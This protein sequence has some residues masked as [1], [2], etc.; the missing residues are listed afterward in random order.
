[1]DKIC[2]L[3]F[4]NTAHDST[5]WC[6]M[7]ECRC[8]GRSNCAIISDGSGIE[9]EE[10]FALKCA[11]CGWMGHPNLEESGP[12]TKATCG[13]DNCGA[14]IKMLSKADVQLLV[15]DTVKKKPKTTRYP[16]MDRASALDTYIEIRDKINGISGLPVAWKDALTNLLGN[17]AQSHNSALSRI[18]ELE[19]EVHCG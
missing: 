12:H 3:E 16:V 6:S 7:K 9:Q 18:E 14:Y 4:I 11:Q 5:V 2:S 13:N 8:M 10:R 15:A 1:M 19:R 17:L